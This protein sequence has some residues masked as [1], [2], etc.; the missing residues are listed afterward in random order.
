MDSYEVF[1]PDG[2][3]VLCSTVSCRYSRQLEGDLLDAGYLIRVNGKRL[4]K[5]E[6][7][8]GNDNA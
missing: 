6:L 1:C 4:T 8:R 3:R 5:A 7:K 2:R